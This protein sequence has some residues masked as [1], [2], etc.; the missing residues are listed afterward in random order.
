MLR[1]NAPAPARIPLVFIFLLIGLFA[2]SSLTL[3]LIGMRVYR[4]V[5]AEADLNGDAQI[6]LSY[7]SNKVHAYD[8]AGGVTVDERGGRPAL[9]LHETIDGTPYETVIYWYQDAVWER[10]APSGEPF[11]PSD[12]ERLI[13]AQALHV[14]MPTPGL[15]EA[16]VLL[17]N[18]EPQSVQVALRTAAKGGVSP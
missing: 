8:A 13:A 16:Q 18:G 6:L 10:F 7:V 9:C 14:S 11:D 15:I 12:G 17:A 5:T 1:R 3:T 4:G 2:V